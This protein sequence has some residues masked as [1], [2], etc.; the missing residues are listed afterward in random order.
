MVT[1]TYRRCRKP[2]PGGLRVDWSPCNLRCFVSA[3]FKNIVFYGVSGPSAARDFILAMLQN[4]GFYV[5]LL[6][7]GA[8]GRNIVILRSFQHRWPK[9]GPNHSS[10]D[11]STWAN[12]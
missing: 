9:H 7:E 10:Q 5:V 1:E 8:R 4:I 2:M 12:I 3:M 6:Q 11:G